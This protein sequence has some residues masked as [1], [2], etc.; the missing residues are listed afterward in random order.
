MVMVLFVFGFNAPARQLANDLNATYVPI[1]VR[2]FPDGEVNPR[3]LLE[4]VL[5]SKD[6]SILTHADIILAAWWEPNSLPINSYLVSILYSLKHLNNRYRPNSLTL[7]LPYHVYARQDKEFRTGEV[8]SSKVL[9]SLLEDCGLTHFVT[10]TSHLARDIPLSRLFKNVKTL[11]V[12][13]VK[14]LASEVKKRVNEGKLQLSLEKSVV[15]AP[16]NNALGWAKEF[17]STL[18]VTDITY[19]LKKRDRDTGEIV[20]SLPDDSTDIKGKTMLLIDDIV[21]TGSTMYKAARIFLDQ[22]ASQVGFCY[23]HAVHSTPESV[24]RLKSLEPVV[25]LT[26]NSILIGSEYEI[27]RVSLVSSFR[28]HL[29]ILLGS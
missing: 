26:T 7:V 24:K 27:E 2:V 10:V 15:V 18:G 5:S 9:S 20:Q 25:L 6:E 21:S 3:I 23:V 1:S 28:D 19:L 22:G 17:A 29:R 13:G 16:D 4:D 11:E 12:S 8:V 14:V